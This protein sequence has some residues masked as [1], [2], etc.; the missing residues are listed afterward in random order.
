DFFHKKTT[1]LLFPQTPQYPA[2]PDA[3]ITWINLPGEVINRGIELNLNGIIIE[4]DDFR[5][6]LGGNATF[7]K[8][9]VQN[10]GESEII[11]TGSLSG[12]GLSD[13]TVQVIQNG[14]PL[15][16]FVTREYLGL[17]EEGFSQFTDDG[18]VFHRV[19]N[20]NP[21]VL[22]GVSTGIDYKRFSFSANF[23]GVIGQDIYNNTANSVLPISNLGSRNIAS[24][25]MSQGILESPANPIAAS[26]RYIENGSYLKLANATLNYRIGN[27]GASIKN[28][29]VFLNGQNIFVITKYKGFDPEVN[30]NKSVNSV[31]SAGI[32]NVTYPAARTFNIGVNFSL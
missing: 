7:V 22:L 10:L 8:N 24:E 6:D 31:P 32:D 26:S 16:A 14:Y 29:G 17:D 19:G 13:V 28:L 30:V 27:V 3:S 23:N 21:R 1:D 4:N 25:L 15:F 18:F 9:S 20:P 2:S 5:W 11:R 12:Q